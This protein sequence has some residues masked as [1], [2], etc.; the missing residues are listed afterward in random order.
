M[1][2][3]SDQKSILN[4]ATLPPPPQKKKKLKRL[5]TK[6]GPPP[7]KSSESRY[8]KT[9]KSQIDSNQKGGI[10]ESNEGE[11]GGD[12]E[13]ND[14]IRERSG[15]RGTIDKRRQQREGKKKKSLIKGTGTQR[16]TGLEN[17]KSRLQDQIKEIG[18]KARR[19]KGRRIKTEK[20]ETNVRNKETIK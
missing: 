4:S 3:K 10:K 18:N 8:G 1:A 15:M 12:G 9:T 16:S 7:P 6:T 11:W 5:K 14:Q 2:Q 13:S 20:S 19:I 17:F